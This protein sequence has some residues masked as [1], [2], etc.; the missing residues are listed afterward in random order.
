MRNIIKAINFELVRSKSVFIFY[1]IF[2]VI[3]G[4]IA[5]LNIEKDAGTSGMILE[6]P[7][8]VTMFPVFVCAMIVAYICCP[9]MRDRVSNYEIMSGHSRLKF[10]LARCFYAVG[11]S[12]LFTTILS[13]VP[14]IIGNIFFGWGDKL[15]LSDV[16]IR[17]I[18]LFFP[19]LRLAAFFVLLSFLVK[20]EYI[21]MA[22]GFIT[23]LAPSIISGIVKTSLNIYISIFN[24]NLLMDMGGWKIYNI[25]PTKGVITYQVGESMITPG[26]VIGTIA[27]S[28]IMAVIYT[29]LGYALFRKND[30]N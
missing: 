4:L 16:I 27:A 5:G 6:S 20:N 3:M 1:S 29:A 12:A 22:A 25:S 23:C 2:A 15:V 17:Q 11:I 8:S 10:Y 21:V 19:Y 9:D 7:T 28:V 18:L 14:M 30:I 24:L 13:F 26:L